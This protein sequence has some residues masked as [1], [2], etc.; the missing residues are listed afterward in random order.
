[1][2]EGLSWDDFGGEDKAAQLLPPGEYRGTITFS[3]FGFQ[4][5]ARTKLPESNGRVWRVKVEID[6]PAGYAMVDTVVPVV[7]A[8]RWQFR[9]I[10]LAAGVEPPSPDGPPWRPDSLH[11]RQVTVTTSIYTNERT[12]ESKVQIDK[13][14]PG[15]V[16]TE[17]PP[18]V[19]PAP[20]SKPARRG[21]VATPPA[22]DDI[23]F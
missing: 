15:A 20:K 7:K 18:A 4:E 1:M 16:L 6:A 19:D 12:G 13:W 10:S 8:R 11:G 22:G 23:P 9:Q 21:P 5:W 3:A 17:V 2:D 14:L